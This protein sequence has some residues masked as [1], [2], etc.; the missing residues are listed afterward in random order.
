MVN[1]RICAQKDGLKE[2]LKKEGFQ[3]VMSFFVPF[4]LHS[5]NLED[6]LPFGGGLFALFGHDFC[7]MAR[8]PMD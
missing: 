7:Q 4:L 6:I 5:F 8:W 1:G 2:E 3:W